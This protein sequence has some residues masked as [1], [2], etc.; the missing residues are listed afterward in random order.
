MTQST[1]SST[2]ARTQARSLTVDPWM[3]TLALIAVCTLLRLAYLIWLTPYELV[4]DEAYYWVQSQHLD[5]SYREKG[6]LLAWMIAL[7]CRTFGNTEWAVRLPV[8]L[9]AA[10]AAWGVGR[11][12]LSLT[13]GDRRAAR[14]AVVVLLLVPAFGANAQICT[15]D[16]PMIA[17]L[18]EL[19]AIGLHLIRQ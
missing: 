19:S 12:T 15:Q 3:L 10:L 6:P 18:V 16:G 5:W 7:C 11:L 2:A 8:V 9:S 17:L 4:G 1:I 14:L 13:R